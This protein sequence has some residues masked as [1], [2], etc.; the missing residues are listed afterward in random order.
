VQ[1]DQLERQ[2][3]AHARS[4]LS[5]FFV[6]AERSSAPQFAERPSTPDRQAQH[7]L[8]IR[9]STGAT[10]NF[11][12]DFNDVAAVP[13]VS[14]SIFHHGPLMASNPDFSSPFQFD[15]FFDHPSL[16]SL[17]YI[18]NVS[19]VDYLALILCINFFLSSPSCR[20]QEDPSLPLITLVRRLSKILILLYDLFLLIYN[21]ADAN[22]DDN[23]S[24]DTTD[25][26]FDKL[27]GIC[28][29]FR[30]HWK[31]LTVHKLFDVPYLQ[32]LPDLDNL[33]SDRTARIQLKLDVIKKIRK[34][35]I[36]FVSEHATST[37]DK[38]KIAPI[39]N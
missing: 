38:T 2:S 37:P 15:V 5:P 31:N 14:I 1:K 9:A 12:R 24:I 17:D 8:N 16:S 23:K 32:N 3:I 30:A 25:L 36:T 20:S 28:V 33:F 29:R 27:D 13:S 21:M 18:A 6:F 4:T 10:W 39:I 26:G 22:D 11:P 19:I 35:I 7:I 34:Q